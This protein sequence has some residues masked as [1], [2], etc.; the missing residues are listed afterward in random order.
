M[1]QP[2]LP[3][4]GRIVHYVSYGSP[5]REDGTQEHVSECCAAIITHVENLEHGFVNLAI[6][7]SAGLHFKPIRH[8]EEKAAGTWHWPERV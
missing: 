7:A 2:Q 1:T 3:S 8:D 6:F 5:V 4:V